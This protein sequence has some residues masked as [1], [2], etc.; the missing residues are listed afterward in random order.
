MQTLIKLFTP[1]LFKILPKPKRYNHFMSRTYNTLFILESLD[2]KISTGS[3]DSL[4]VDQDFKRIHGVKEGLK[5]YYDLEKTTDPFSFNSGRVMAKIGVNKRTEE[6]EK[7]G[8]S[9]IIVDNKPHLN[10]NGII[11]LSKWVKTLFLVTTNPNH[12]SLKLKNSLGNI[13]AILYKDEVDFTNLFEQM[14]NKY[15]AEK[16]TIQSGGTLNAELLRNKLIDEVSI[17]IAPCLVGGSNTATLVD[18]N[19]HQTETD[20]L[21]IRPLKLKEAKTLN[22]S[23]LHIR[24]AVIN[25]INID[26]KITK[27]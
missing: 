23:Y 27:N 8:C 14:R 5:Q 24:Y 15:Q 1:N 17:V 19:S 7:M 3:V 20:L 12:P 6:P 2:G 10:E 4:D 13:V 16:I 21:N 26:P 25:D 18:G 9:F 22:N 11:Y